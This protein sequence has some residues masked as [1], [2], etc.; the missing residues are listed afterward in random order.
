[1]YAVREDVQGLVKAI[2]AVCMKAAQAAHD[3]YQL[4][5]LSDMNAGKR[6]VPIR[7]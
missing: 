6:L 1:M 7:Y 4:I 3:G 2:D 5:V